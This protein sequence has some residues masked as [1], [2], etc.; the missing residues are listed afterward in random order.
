MMITAAS[1]KYSRR[2]KTKLAGSPVPQLGSMPPGHWG[3]R[4]RY[5]GSLQV[6]SAPHPPK[7][8]Q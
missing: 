6:V 8:G 4:L 1:I 7:S 2:L 5:Q 3:D